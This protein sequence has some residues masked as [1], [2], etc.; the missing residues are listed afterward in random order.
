MQYKRYVVFVLLIILLSL[1]S[2][3]TIRYEPQEG[4]WYCEE[5]QM[6]LSYEQDTESFVTEG[7]R[8]IRVYC[9]TDRGSKWIGVNSAI[10][11]DGH[12]LGG[13]VV[14]G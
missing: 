11:A 7:N 9:E 3:V 12:Y 10:S 2:C 5:L 1:T 14:S 6:Q 8:K 4:V 13:T